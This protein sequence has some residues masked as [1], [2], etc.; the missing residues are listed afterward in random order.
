MDGTQKTNRMEENVPSWSSNR[1]NSFVAVAADPV[2][3]H[4][5]NWTG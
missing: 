5:G 1:K 4:R 2:G 3:I